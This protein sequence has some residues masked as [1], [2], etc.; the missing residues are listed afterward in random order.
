MSFSPLI[1]SLQILYP[2]WIFHFLNSNCIHSILIQ[3]LFCKSCLIT[4]ESISILPIP[5]IIFR[6]ESVKC[7][8]ATPTFLKRVESVKSLCNLHNIMLLPTVWNMVAAN[9]KLPSAFSNCIGF[10]LWGMA[11]LPT[12]FSTFFKKKY[13]LLQ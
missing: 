9:F 6:N 1:Y 10:I 12:S 7:P 3:L 8:K 4:A 5:E 2:S 13:F 11:E